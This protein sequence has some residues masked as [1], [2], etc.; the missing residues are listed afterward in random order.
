VQE[1]RRVILIAIGHSIVY[2]PCGSFPGRE[3]K[4]ASEPFW[5]NS[6]KESGKIHMPSSWSVYSLFRRKVNQGFAGADDGFQFGLCSVS[7]FNLSL[8]ECRATY[9][10][11]HAKAMQRRRRSSWPTAPPSRIALP[12]ALIRVSGNLSSPISDTPTL[13]VGGAT[14]S[15]I[16]DRSFVSSGAPHAN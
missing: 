13:R 1:F 16:V 10:S 12:E 15:L 3:T 9:A 4:S 2:L 6:R 7:G 8:G 14:H 5:K 11:L